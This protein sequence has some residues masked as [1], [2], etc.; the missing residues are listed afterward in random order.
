MRLGTIPTLGR[1]GALIGVYFKML[2]EVGKLKGRI[3]MLERQEATVMN[4][5]E[6]LVTSVDELK[7]L[8]RL[9]SCWHRKASIEILHLLRVRLPRPPRLRP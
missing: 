9:S 6:K 2:T 1:V 5:L 4:M 3:A 7:L 8:L